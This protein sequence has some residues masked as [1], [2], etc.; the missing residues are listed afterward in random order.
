MDLSKERIVYLLKA[1]S[2]NTA[3]E[4]EEQEL[5]SWVN[6]S[7]YHIPLQQHIATLT[8][9]Y[10]SHEELPLVDWEHLYDQI[11]DKALIKQHH[12]VPRPIVWLRWSASAAAIFLIAASVYWYVHSS[13]KRVAAV[14]NKE[15][16]AMRDIAAPADTKAVLTLADGSRIALDSISDGTLAKQGNVHIVKQADGR[17]TYNGAGTETLYNTLNVPR[18]SKV[19]TISLSDGTQVWLNSESSLRYPAA[20]TGSERRVEITGE[21]Y[22]EVTHNAAMPFLVTKND[23]EIK[24]LGTHFNI[25][26]YN[27]EGTS[28][29][30]LLEGSVKVS[31]LNSQSFLKPGQQAQIGNGIRLVKGVNLEEVMSWKNGMF[32][33]GQK[34]DLRLIM[35]KIARWYDVDVDY[36]GTAI[37]QQFGGEMPMSSNL[38][39]VL[40]ILKTSGVKFT[41]EGKKV[42]VKS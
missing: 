41:I 40:E 42:I 15:L 2:N 33:F 36:E 21:A 26:T 29:V 23:M 39:Q 24:V 25:N 3:T 11:L 38:S 1:Y 37:N 18:G 35:K 14:V 12:R 27:D 28:K 16:P 4:D 34:A 7:D 19:V 5:F 32:Q 10:N 17:I 20:F 6:E 9:Q 30:T 8:G 22:F 13:E 31:K